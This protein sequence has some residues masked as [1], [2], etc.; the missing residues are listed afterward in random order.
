MS[1]VEDNLKYLN[2]LNVPFEY[3]EFDILKGEERDNIKS[4][5]ICK[6]LV[7]KGKKTGIIILSIPIN[8]QA[9]W[10]K[11]KSFL[12]DKKV[13]LVDNVEEITSYPH[14]ANGAIFISRNYPEYT[15]LIDESLLDYD[16][17]ITNSGEYAKTI[18]IKKEDFLKIVPHQ[19][20]NF[21]K[22]NTI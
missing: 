6:T 11:V 20:G 16:K 21:I 3:I 14:G 18:F 4:E 8:R 9:D 19:K 2:E 17:I 13:R 1:R 12:E 7:A 15:Y 10:N 5:Q 22:E